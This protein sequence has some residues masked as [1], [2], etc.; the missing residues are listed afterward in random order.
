MATATAHGALARMRLARLRSVTRSR[1]DTRPARW[2]PVLVSQG[3]QVFSRK[4]IGLAGLP[5]YVREAEGLVEKAMA[6]KDRGTRNSLFE[7]AI[8]LVVGGVGQNKRAIHDCLL[9]AECCWELVRAQESIEYLKEAIQL[10]PKD[11]RPF[12]LLGRYLVYKGLRD[13][14]LNFLDRAIQLDPDD[15]ATRKLR[16]RAVLQKKKQYTVVVNTA[17]AAALAPQ[18]KENQ[19]LQRKAEATRLLDLGQIKEAAAE[20]QNAEHGT[21]N[22]LDVA[23]ASLLGGNLTAADISILL[24]EAPPTR[25]GGIVRAILGFMF[26]VLFGLAGGVLFGNNCQKKSGSASDSVAALVLSDRTSSL[27]DAATKVDETP[28]DVSLIG[29]G[30]VAHAL[31]YTEHAGEISHREAALSLLSTAADAAQKSH[32]ALFARALLAPLP[33]VEPDPS[34][35]DDID[36]ATKATTTHSTF[37]ALA[38]AERL[39]HQGDVTG[40][41]ALLRPAAFGS[42]PSARAL[43]MLA[44]R[45]AELGHPGAAIALIERLW[46]TTPL[47]G[48]SLATAALIAGMGDAFSTTK[49]PDGAAAKD[50][51]AGKPGDAPGSD[52]KDA[53]DAKDETKGEKGENGEKKESDDA[54]VE[55]TG[56]DQ[57]LLDRITAIVEGDAIH[58]LDAAP[59]AIVLALLALARGDTAQRDKMLSIAIGSSSSGPIVANPMLLDGVTM[60]RILDFD[61]KGALSL[62]DKNSGLVDTTIFLQRNVTRATVLNGLADE[63]RAM[64]LAA[65]KPSF[66]PGALALPAGRVVVDM[67]RTLLPV[68]AEFDTRYFP[69]TAMQ[70]VLELKDLSPTVAKRTFATVANIK[71]AQIAL[72]KENTAMALDYLQKAKSTGGNNPDYYLMS[73]IV[74]AADRNK[75]QAREDIEEALDLAPDEP[76]ILVAAARIQ[77][78]GGDAVAAV[79]SLNKLKDEGFVSPAALALMARALAKKG[80]LAGARASIAEARAITDDD[81][82]IHV[83]EIHVEDAV[84][85]AER[86]IS[87]GAAAVAVSASRARALVQSD[88]VAAPYLLYTLAQGAGAASSIDL[89]K[90]MTEKKRLGA[91]PVYALGLVLVGK[92]ETRAEGLTLLKRAAT[93]GGM[94]ALAAKRKADELEGKTVEPEKAPEPAPAPPPKKKSKKKGR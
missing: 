75:A 31:L 68:S 55:P 36:E 8:S 35:D 87:A 23:L 43:H 22:A 81:I 70:T 80:D 27:I 94:A 91:A 88:P 39:R 90:D 13:Q 92:E 28:E 33:D 64:R 18:K 10:A 38:R 86:A 34:V 56:V 84:G 58:G 9:L 15:Q 66:M 61:P 6:E 1:D 21:N 20:L 62:L 40:A 77:L 46:K 78:A 65:G 2:R 25:A 12:A 26:V 48:P 4:Q 72:A 83:A 16:E 24:P 29:L 71:L 11:A 32:P 19:Q 59:P 63:L 51:I 7:K 76:K 69:E 52:E 47:H 74:Y 37:L 44:R 30:A 49:A 50:G 45:E 67:K 53:K 60:V 93:L 54:S 14:A 42:E 73:A 17:D 57:A 5:D 3:T 89:L 41:L 82:D 85:E 79:R